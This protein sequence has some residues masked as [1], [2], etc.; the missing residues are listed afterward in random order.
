MG[1][2]EYP[3]MVL[4]GMGQGIFRYP[5]WPWR[6]GG[7]GWEGVL[8][9]GSGCV[10]PHPTP[11]PSELTNKVK[12]LPSLILHMQVVKITGWI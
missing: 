5:S 10:T 7:V 11:P 12:T 3:K 2:A 1:W 8:C 6:G 4:A 9:P